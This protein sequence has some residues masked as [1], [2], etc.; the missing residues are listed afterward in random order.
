MIAAQAEPRPAH[1]AW[2]SAVAPR[3]AAPPHIAAPIAPV[4]A[5]APTASALGMAER[6][7]LPPPKPISLFPPSDH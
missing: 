5:T 1:V 7:S 2:L 4:A 3:P 6:E